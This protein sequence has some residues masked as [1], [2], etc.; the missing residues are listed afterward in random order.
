MYKFND[1]FHS[2]HFYIIKNECFPNL[3]KH[4]YPITNQVDILI[5]QL[6]DKLNIYNITETVTQKEFFTNS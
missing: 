1:L 4:M 5:A 3:F 2:A 6:Y